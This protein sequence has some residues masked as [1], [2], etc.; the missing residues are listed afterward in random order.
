MRYPTPNRMRFEDWTAQLKNAGGLNFPNP[1]PVEK[2]WNWVDELKQLNSQNN[3]I[4]LA[5]R[6]M[7]PQVI[8]WMR[9]GQFF[10]NNLNAN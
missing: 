2:W 1:L 3:N 4:P 7:Y 5:S 6:N 9:W 10:L 8:D